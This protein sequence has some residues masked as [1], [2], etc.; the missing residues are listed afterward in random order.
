MSSAL[1]GLA[2]MQDLAPV[3]DWL[4]PVMYSI[5]A[6]GCFQLGVNVSLTRHASAR[7]Q[8]I[9]FLLC[10][11]YLLVAASCLVHGDTLWVQWARAFAKNQQVYEFRRVVQLGMLL[12]L[13]VGLSLVLRRQRRV[14]PLGGQG[15]DTLRRLMLAGAAGTVGL[16]ILR[17][18]SFHYT[19]LVLSANLV[20]HSVAFWVEFGS[21]GVVGLTSGLVI[22]RGDSNV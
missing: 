4:R 12:A 15:P 6:F 3:D 1:S 14:S 18:V 5:A 17:Y 16:Y 19:D 10:P 2:V 21:L 9:W 22:L 20:G 7:L 8:Q 11:L 13:V